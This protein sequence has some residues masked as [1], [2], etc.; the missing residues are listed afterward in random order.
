M[1]PLAK[2]LAFTTDDLSIRVGETLGGLINATFGNAVELIVSII[3]LTKCELTIVQSSLVGSI[4]SNIL[5][6]LG[7]CFFAGGM[8]FAEQGFQLNSAQLNST[9]LTLSVIVILLPGAFHLAVAKK[10][11]GVDPL[12][13]F[14]EGQDIL[15]M[16]HGV[17]FLVLFIYGSYLVFQLWSHAYWYNDP[18]AGTSV[19]YVP[20]NQ[21]RT[22]EDV[23]VAK[24]KEEV[25]EPQ[26]SLPLALGLLVVITV[27]V[28]FTTEFLV[29]SID[30]LTDTGKIS[31]EWVGLILLPIIGNGPAL[32]TAVT[33][34]VKD[35]L[36]LSISVVVG[37]SIQIALF[38]I[39]T[40]TLL[41]W[42]MGR[43]LTLL[44]DPFETIILLLSILTVASVVQDGRS[45]WLEGMVLIMLF[46][47]IATIAWFYP[48][49]D[50]AG[51]LYGGVCH[52][53][54]LHP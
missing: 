43:N 27:L 42:M 22:V 13:D 1:V 7:M 2:L 37:S 10:A 41:G 8:R 51:E 48:G 39:P 20:R 33:V 16:S 40:V 30:G 45:N 26:M 24:K 53:N 35:K 47:I 21:M 6:V 50:V 12:T 54:Q 49:N 31:K 46:V 18:K 19:K 34:S 28:A 9:L 5:L 11:N 4:L 25:E 23:E 3:A 32:L 15:R 38:V 52:T 29:K 36:D 44:F 14:K 17:A